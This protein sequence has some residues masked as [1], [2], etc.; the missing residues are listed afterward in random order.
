MIIWACPSCV[1]SGFPL[2][3]RPDRMQILAAFKIQSVI[4]NIK[5]VSP[6][7]SLQSLTR[8]SVL[9][10]GFLVLMLPLCPEGCF[11]NSICPFEVTAS[12]HHL[13]VTTFI[14]RDTPFINANISII[15]PF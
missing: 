1:G 11:N 7:F 3:V 4:S 14:K 9:V 6:G 15:P 12:F 13:G 10:S 5:P 8:I 2:Q